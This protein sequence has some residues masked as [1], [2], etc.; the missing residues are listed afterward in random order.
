M[1]GRKGNISLINRC[2][3]SNLKIDDVT[4]LPSANKAIFCMKM[5]ASREQGFALM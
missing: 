2:T 5:L 3:E 1:G 4:R